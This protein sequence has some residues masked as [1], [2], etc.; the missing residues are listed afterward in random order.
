VRGGAAQIVANLPYNI[1]T[2]MLKRALPLGDAF[3]TVVLLIQEE[4]RRTQRLRSTPHTH[5]HTRLRKKGVC[6]ARARVPWQACDQDTL[7]PAARLRG[8]GGAAPGG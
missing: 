5:G 8:A 1:T 7:R 4:A 2:D 3:S 6:G